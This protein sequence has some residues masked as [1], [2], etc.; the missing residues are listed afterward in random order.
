M[1]Q[2][3]DGERGPA[4]AQPRGAQAGAGAA[5]VAADAAAGHPHGPGPGQQRGGGPDEEEAASGGAARPERPDT[6][7]DPVRF[8]LLGETPQVKALVILVDFI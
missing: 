3:K 4:H 6:R 1:L 5:G 7:G 2:K 8:E